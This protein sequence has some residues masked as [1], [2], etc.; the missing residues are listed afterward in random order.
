MLFI[1]EW[2]NSEPVMLDYSDRVMIS[3]EEKEEY[4]GFVIEVS[5]AAGRA[6]LPFFRAEVEASNKL[7][8]QMYDPVTQ[9]DL[10]CEKILR[11][12]IDSRYPQ[13]GIYGEEFGFKEGNGLT[14]VIDPIDG[15]R[16]FMAGLLHWGVLVALF[17]GQKPI[18]GLMYQPYTEELWFGDTTSASFASSNDQRLLKTSNKKGLESAILGTTSHRFFENKTE[19]FNLLEDA[20]RIST[21]GGDCYLYAM[22]AMGQID[23]VIDSGLKPYD[24][25]PLIPIVEGAGGIVTSSEGGNGS[26]GG[27]IV[28]SAN[29]EL[30]RE[31]LRAFNGSA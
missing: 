1:F 10:V 31:V 28:A 6:T 19:D 11:E 5:R 25:Q 22:L 2:I 20:V 30:H 16:A 27:T 4:L 21:Y 15:T 18:L 26:L 3:D 17:D 9:A 14:W 24:I 23:I 12:A 29:G 7:S 8:G 13:H